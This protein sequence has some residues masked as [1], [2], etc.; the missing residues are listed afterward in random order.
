MVN[1]SMV[2]PELILNVMLTHTNFL[3]LGQTIPVNGGA[4]I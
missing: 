1:G 3:R 4:N 2:R